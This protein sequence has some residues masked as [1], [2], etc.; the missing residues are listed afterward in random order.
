VSTDP[1]EIVAILLAVT[2]GVAGLDLARVAQDAF[3]V[4][5]GALQLLDAVDQLKMGEGAEV[6][7]R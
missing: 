6:L 2:A 5:E 7:Q 4:A 1:L 3:D